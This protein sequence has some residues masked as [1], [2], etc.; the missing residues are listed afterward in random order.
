VFGSADHF[1]YALDRATGAERW[2]FDSGADVD[3]TPVIHEGRVL[4]GNRG[5]GLH[6]LASDSGQLVWK[7]FF[8]GS[9]VESTPVVRDG[10]IYIGSSDLRIAADTTNVHVTWT[11]L[12]TAKKTVRAPSASSVTPILSAADCRSTGSLTP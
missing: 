7:Q 9:W 5:Y 11:D 2:R 3:A 12:R 10:V 4:I 8:W 6:S 1:V